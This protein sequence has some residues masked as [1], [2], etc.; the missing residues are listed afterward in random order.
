M[1]SDISSG[2]A[3][4]AISQIACCR[5]LVAVALF[6]LAISLNGCKKQAG[7]DGASGDPQVSATLA[8]LTRE[9]HHAMMGRKLSRDFDEFVA[10]SHVEVPPPP[11][12]KKYAINEKWKVVLVDQKL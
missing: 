3:S 5:C 9:L 7:G 12:G 4:S 8:Q 10:L 11:P 6:A 2:A 1:K